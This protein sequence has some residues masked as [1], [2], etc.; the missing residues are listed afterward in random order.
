MTTQRRLGVLGGTHAGG[1]LRGL[2]GGGVGG[3][4]LDVGL[5][6][7]RGDLYLG[8]LA[9]G[10]VREQ[11][12]VGR[13]GLEVVVR[14]LDGVARGNADDGADGGDRSGRSHRESPDRD[15]AHTVSFQHRPH[16]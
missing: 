12:G 14:G 8:L 1:F 3:G 10:D 2:A 4:G 5:L 9:R 15:P 11:R 6:R 13:G 7:E 16:A